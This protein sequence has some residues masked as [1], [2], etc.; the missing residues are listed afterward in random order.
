M[1]RMNNRLVQLLKLVLN[2]CPPTSR[3]AW[4]ICFCC[5][6]SD[7]RSSSYRARRRTRGP[8][9]GDTC[10]PPRSARPAS[11][12]CSHDVT[13]PT[14]RRTGWCTA[15]STSNNPNRTRCSTCRCSRSSIS[16]HTSS[17]RSRSLSSTFSNLKRN[18]RPK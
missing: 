5:Y 7:N 4:L 3:T 12:R 16:R 8:E 14:N 9:S 1:P 15:P 2:K 10:S 13:T 11:S 17:S 6:R 18:T